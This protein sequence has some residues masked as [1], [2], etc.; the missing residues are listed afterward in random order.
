MGE[1][2]VVVEEDEAVET[3]EREGC[4]KMLAGDTQQQHQH[5]HQQWLD[6]LSEEAQRFF[7]GGERDDVDDDDET[8]I[9]N[10]KNK[11]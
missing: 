1:A 7:L 10:S 11:V 2:E 4:G 5:Q 3:D 8:F 6:G 9:F